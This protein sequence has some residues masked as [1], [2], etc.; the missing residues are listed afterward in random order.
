MATG[1]DDTDSNQTGNRHRWTDSTD[2]TDGQQPAKTGNTIS[3]ASN[4]NALAGR[5]GTANGYCKQC[6]VIRMDSKDTF[7]KV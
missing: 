3:T 7:G 5:Y 6:V 2:S 1:T 4:S